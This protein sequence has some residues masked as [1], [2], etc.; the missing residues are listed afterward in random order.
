[1]SAIVLWEITQ[2]RVEGRMDLANGTS[3]PVGAEKERPH[4]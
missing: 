3:R 4:E 1:M 2:L